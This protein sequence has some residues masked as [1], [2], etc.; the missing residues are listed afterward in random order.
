MT[1]E[2]RRAY[3]RTVN[4]KAKYGIT[5]AQAEQLLKEQGGRC[6]V[7]GYKVAFI[8]E[9]KDRNSPIKA[10]VDHCHRTG[11]VRGILH[12]RCNR[13]LGFL[14]DSADIAESAADY[15]RRNM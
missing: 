5:F 14:L 11:K 12:D 8:E 1:P 3:W 9:P 4:M 2:A 13:A 7:C 15:L 6:A 10:V